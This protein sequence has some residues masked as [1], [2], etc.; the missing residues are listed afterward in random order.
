FDGLK[1]FLRTSNSVGL[2]FFTPSAQKLTR[3]DGSPLSTTSRNSPIGPAQ[4]PPSS[5][6][7]LSTAH[8]SSC[9]VWPNEQTLY[10]CSRSFDTQKL[11]N[12]RSSLWEQPLPQSVDN[13][14]RS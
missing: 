7:N 11:T 9:V 10:R 6:Y 3:F 4:L 8:S 2:I 1:C 14:A 5:E 12:R 13:G